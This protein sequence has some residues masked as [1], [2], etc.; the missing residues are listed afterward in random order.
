MVRGDTEVMARARA[1][2]RA[3]ARRSLIQVERGP[4]A[5]SLAAWKHYPNPI[6]SNPI[7][8]SPVQSSPIQSRRVEP[9]RVESLVTDRLVIVARYT[10][11]FPVGRLTADLDDEGGDVSDANATDVVPKWVWRRKDESEEME[12]RK[13]LVMVGLGTVRVGLSVPGFYGSE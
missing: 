13:G 2:T 12:D 1:R 11:K 9:S 10:T 4:V 5:R 8:S 6:Q 7:Q 3:R